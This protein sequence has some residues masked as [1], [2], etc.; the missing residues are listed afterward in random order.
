[1]QVARRK[2]TRALMLWAI[3]LCVLIAVSIPIGM[4]LRNSSIIENTVWRCKNSLA[5][6]GELRP[7]SETKIRAAIAQLRKDFRESASEAS[8]IVR[9]FDCG[10]DD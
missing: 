10:L 5:A 8:R 4:V 6:S 9:A 3:G 7:D 1:M 2:F